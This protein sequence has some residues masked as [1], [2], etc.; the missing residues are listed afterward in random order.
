MWCRL[1]DAERDAVAVAGTADSL[2]HHDT[3][4][5][6][7]AGTRFGRATGQWGLG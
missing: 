3:T 4:S 7:F 6:F 5:G 2:S 1:S